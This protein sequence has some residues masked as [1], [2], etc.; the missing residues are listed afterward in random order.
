ME[1][2]YTMPRMEG[3]PSVM[4]QTGV[5]GLEVCGVE[6]EGKQGVYSSINA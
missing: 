1:G 2:G 4:I 3:Y 6:G 5:C